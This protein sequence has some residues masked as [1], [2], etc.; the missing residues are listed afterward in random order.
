[1]SI[2][3]ISALHKG[4]MLNPNHNLIRATKSTI[5]ATSLMLATL[6]PLKAASTDMY[7]QE[8]LTENTELV[9]NKNIDP[10]IFE[11]L[12]ITH[13]Q[14]EICK[15]ILNEYLDNEY[16]KNGKWY[17]KNAEYYDS[18]ILP[19]S[20]PTHTAFLN[21]SNGFD[22]K[23]AKIRVKDNHY[24][25]YYENKFSFDPTLTIK[26][27]NEK[28]GDFTV[29]TLIEGLSNRKT[30]VLNFTK[31]GKLKKGS[32]LPN[33]NSLKTN[34][35]S[36]EAPKDD[37]LNSLISDI[38]GSSFLRCYN[39]K[40]IAKIAQALN[41]NSIESA[42]GGK[43][44]IL[45]LNGDNYTYRLNLKKVDDDWNTILGIANKVN[46]QGESEIYL[47]KGEFVYT[48]RSDKLI[49]SKMKVVQ[50]GLDDNA[51]T[52]KKDLKV[53][54]KTGR[55]NSSTSHSGNVVARTPWLANLFSLN[56]R[57]FYDGEI[58]SKTLNEMN[59]IITE[60]NPDG[61]TVKIISVDKLTEN[62]SIQ[63]K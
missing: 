26:I 54:T 52:I 5:A 18:S 43:A 9:S 15:K 57:E 45:F 58:S 34:K 19:F 17:F 51:P 14:F 4:N 24:E 62:V 39:H 42:N 33:T 3:R 10:Q 21:F 35:R 2:N 30:D 32:Y 11:K 48:N 59:E 27:E 61:K 23:S 44:N 7:L 12:K 63:G 40:F 16:K 56:H 8:S 6:M 1:M 49:I 38:K 31:D 13:V 47:V 41:L 36:E 60:S 28:N 50:D 22:K 53:T 25:I 46:M 20:S 55:N 29:S 37:T